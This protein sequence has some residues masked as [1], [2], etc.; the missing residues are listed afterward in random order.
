MKGH[1]R[2]EKIKDLIGAINRDEDLSWQRVSK[3]YKVS[4]QTALS[5]IEEAEQQINQEKE[6]DI[7]WHPTYS[8]KENQENRER[9]Q[10]LE[11]ERQQQLER[12]RQQ[13]LERERQQ[14]LERE[15]QQQLERERQQKDQMWKE[16]EKR[17]EE[18]RK[19]ERENREK[20]YKM[21]PEERKQ[22]KIKRQKILKEELLKDKY[23]VTPLYW[24]IKEREAKESQKNK[25][26]EFLL[27]KAKQ[28]ERERQKHSAT[29]IFPGY[30]K[31]E[32]K[33]QQEK[34]K[35]AI[36]RTII[37]PKEP[38]NTTNINSA[39][40]QYKGKKISKY[41]ALIFLIIIY[42]ICLIAIGKNHPIIDLF[43]TFLFGIVI[44]LTLK[45]I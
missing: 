41:S 24:K 17:E 39:A 9:Q 18:Q 36:P 35:E 16:A 23:N 27:E 22:D 7:V 26:E 6:E 3:K 37:L 25:E 45:W 1:I 28:L 31:V 14:Q 12:E 2:Q 40:K 34:Q 21:T 20:Y 43:L 33:K 10:Q 11:R 42:F 44:V 38:S 32:K 19:W 30:Y 29:W 13:Q 8:D 15:R 5:Y 4:K